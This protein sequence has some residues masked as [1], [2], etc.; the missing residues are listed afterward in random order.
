M[1]A[2]QS[3]P[4][5]PRSRAKRM[6]GRATY[7]HAAVHA[8]LDAGFLAHVSYVI[9][10]QP[11]CTPTIHWRH[12]TRLYWHGSSASRMLRNL[13]KGTPVCVTVSHL[14]GLVL[15]RSGFNHSA[16]YRSAMCFGT[17]HLI[18]DPAE[19]AA[20]LVA[21]TDRFYPG[22]NA[23]LRPITPQEAKATTVIGMQ[24]DEATAKVRND[25]VG[26]DEADLDLPI[27]AGVIPVHTVLGS[28]TDSPHLPP[29]V[30]R[31]QHISAYAPHARLDD[32][33][34]AMYA[35]NAGLAAPET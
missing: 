23:T 19:K 16:N 5:T 7:D 22:R 6:Y 4:M 32:V 14:D 24:I 30:D 10:G 31:P 8:I 15:A 20:A 18:D 3:Y 1:S 25:G 28:V 2:S 11:Y 26:D 13:A 34:T 21:V 12:G 17:A 27:W 9:D 35:A 33:L 29:G